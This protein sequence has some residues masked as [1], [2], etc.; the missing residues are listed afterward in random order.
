MGYVMKVAMLV[1][2]SCENDSRVIKEAEALAK[3][4]HEVRVYCLSQ[5]GLPD[6]QLKNGVTYIRIPLAMGWLVRWGMSILRTVKL[7]TYA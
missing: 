1:M 6:N 5:L 4:G 3:N 7:K 2:N